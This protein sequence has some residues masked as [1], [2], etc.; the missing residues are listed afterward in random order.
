MPVVVVLYPCGG[1]QG[2]AVTRVPLGALL[3]TIAYEVPVFARRATRPA[4]TIRQPAERRFSWRLGA[5]GRRRSVRSSV[6]S[7]TSVRLTNR[8]TGYS[9]RP[10]QGPLPN[11]AFDAPC[12]EHGLF[13]LPH[14]LDVPAG[15]CE[16]LVDSAITLGVGGELWDPVLLVA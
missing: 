5:S 3:A 15:G 4:P 2:S 6:V 13:V 11:P 12:G 14:T 16:R 1:I 9:S 8:S 10:R 7:L